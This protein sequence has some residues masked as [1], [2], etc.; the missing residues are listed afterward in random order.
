MHGSRRR[1]RR[2]DVVLPG[3]V[4]T[5][6]GSRPTATGNVCQGGALIQVDPDTEPDSLVA[7]HLELPTG[8]PLK[9][10]G[11]VCHVLG[12]RAGIEFRIVPVRSASALREWLE[13]WGRVHQPERRQAERSVRDLVVWSA[14]QGPPRGYASRDISSTG[15]FVQTTEPYRVGAIV[16]FLLVD[17]AADRSIRIRARVVRTVRR[18]EPDEHGIGVA[19]VAVADER[20]LVRLLSSTTTG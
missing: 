15:M 9:L 20:G 11:R 1:W 5:R 18:G 19:F 6:R 17:P 12:K 3:Q 10:V 14:D 2:Y 7:L 13:G 16:D 8:E 4:D